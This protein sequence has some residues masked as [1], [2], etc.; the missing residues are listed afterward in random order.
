MS[1]GG[2]YDPHS[3][4]PRI[5][6][7][8][9]K[10]G[11]FHAEPDANRK[12]YV[13]D[14][15]LPNVT[16]SLHLGHALNN[17]LQDTL[18]RRA[19]MLGFNAMWMPGTDHAGIAT[20]AVVEKKLR[21]NEGITR[22]ELGR[23][24]L[25][26]RI[27]Q[28]KEEYGGR[29]LKQ[30]RRI[31][32]SCDWERTRFTLD[33]VCAKAVYEAFFR[34][35]KDGL[36]Y[37]GLRL[38]N[39]DAHLQTAVADDEIVHETV[40][41]HLWHYR[42]P[43]LQKDEVAEK[44]KAGECE[45]PVRTNETGENEPLVC[46]AEIAQAAIGRAVAED[47]EMGRDYLS[48]ATTRPETM[49][50]DSAIAVHPEDE[51]YKHL[52]GHYVLLPLQN[53]A[54]PVIADGL[55]VKP[56]FGTGCVKVTP[57]HDPNDYACGKR[58]NLPETNILTIDGKINENGGQYAGQDRNDARK[59]IVKDLEEAGLLEKVEPYTHE[60]G[61]SDRSKTPIEPM[62]SEQWFV[63]MADK[64]CRAGAGARCATGA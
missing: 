15:P 39:W 18:T 47:A 52:I 27:W 25:V 3:I 19:R 36:I 30:L 45:P 56:E 7:F 35:F 29:I 50:G 10:A 31:G 2:T 60:V 28:W 24:G 51:R 13:I 59:Q 17:T 8:W 22:H 16:G 49:L 9:E 37:R 33:E 43:V 34:Y 55:L 48:I 40:Q 5:Y 20:Q 23:E 14:I 54:I 41:G 21:E 12:S 53:H 26:E 44:P 6:E 4:E 42:Y 61:H 46:S 11:Y 38:V 1:N 64:L 58:H 57:G 63:N 32:A 62:L